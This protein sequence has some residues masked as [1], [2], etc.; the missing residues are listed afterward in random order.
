MREQREHAADGP[1]QALFR[2][3]RY[4]SRR[5]TGAG[6]AVDPDQ[7]RDVM[8]TEAVQALQD[9]GGATVNDVADELGIDQSGASRFIA[10]AVNRGYLRKIA[11]PHDARQRRLAVTDTGATLVE[12]AHEWQE[13]VFAELTADWSQAEVKQFHHLME[14]LIHS[15]RDRGQRPPGH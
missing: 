1:G 5:W 10:Q 14:R 15:R 13:K 3:V 7:G 4:W 9:R 8:V 12:A 2:F 11:S 6:Q